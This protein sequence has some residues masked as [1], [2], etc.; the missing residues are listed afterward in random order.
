MPDLPVST[1]PVAQLCKPSL[2]ASKLLH[3]LMQN[4]FP[5]RLF[6]ILETYHF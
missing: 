4:S 5:S 1:V 6:F 2:Q 3:V